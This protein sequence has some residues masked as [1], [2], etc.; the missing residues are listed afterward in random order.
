MIDVTIPVLGIAFGLSAK[1]IDLID[2]NKWIVGKTGFVLKYGFVLLS[3]YVVFLSLDADRNLTPYFLS[4]FLFWILRGKF[5]YPSHVL[6]AF[7]PAMLIGRH[8]TGEYLALGIAGLAVYGAL[9]YLIR[10][11]KGWIVQVLLYRSLAR[12][13]VVPFGLGLYLDDFNPL[14]YTIPGL[15]SMH[16]VRYLIRKDF[17]CIREGIRT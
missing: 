14:W 16:V 8:L 17:I 9:E 4:L 6:F 15:L 1:P 5:G 3:G 10:R 13:L 7:I 12:F 2:E 11:F